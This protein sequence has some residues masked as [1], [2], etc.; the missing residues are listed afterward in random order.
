MLGVSSNFF[1][2]SH[3]NSYWFRSQI[4]VWCFSSIFSFVSFILIAFGVV[5]FGWSI[6]GRVLFL[7]RVMR[8]N[9]TKSF[10]AIQNTELRTWEEECRWKRTCKKPFQMKWTEHVERKKNRLCDWRWMRT[11]RKWEHNI[12]KGHRYIR[13]LC[14]YTI[15]YDTILYCT[16]FRL[17]SIQLKLDK[18]G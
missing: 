4:F 9:Q 2:T 13:M 3:F 5:F 7:G 10:H 18:C 8:L 12:G 1:S 6:N 17:N 15:R 11:P 16:I 14:I